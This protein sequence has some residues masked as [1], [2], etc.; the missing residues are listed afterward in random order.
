[1]VRY[2]LADKRV[3]HVVHV[4]DVLIGQACKLANLPIQVVVVLD[5]LDECLIA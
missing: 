2:C 1:M 4:D 5:T 3:V